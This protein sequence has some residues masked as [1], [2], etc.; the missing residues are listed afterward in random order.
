[1]PIA[2]M[3]GADALPHHRHI[4]VKLTAMFAWGF[5]E[6]CAALCLVVGFAL[7][8]ALISLAGSSMTADL[9]G[10][11][12]MTIVAVSVAIFLIARLFR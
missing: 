9:S 11:P 4:L 10:L 5:L 3:A 6:S 1:V 7:V 12:G 2:V 8:R